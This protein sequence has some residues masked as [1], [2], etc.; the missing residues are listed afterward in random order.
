MMNVLEYG[1]IKSSDYHV[2]VL[3][4]TDETSTEREY[5]AVSVAGR[6]G[7]LHFD[8]GRY[9]NV[10]RRYQCYAREHAKDKVA[11][12]LAALLSLH[13]YQRIEDSMNPDYYKIGELAGSVEPRFSTFKSGA[14]FDLEFDCKP[15]KWLKSGEQ[16]H[17]ITTSGAIYN[18]TKFGSK[19]LI[20]I[21][22]YGNLG[23][24][25]DT[26][27]ISSGYSGNMVID[28]DT[29]DAYSK[30]GHANLNSYVTL[31]GGDFPEL[32]SGKN[33]ITCSSNL[34]VEIIPRWWTL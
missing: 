5:E 3:N 9:T 16:S 2:Y 26:I 25:G 7:D 14:R 23:I 34:S 33:N 32:K 17:V 28:F 31:T 29:G 20:Y 24:G 13:G 19:P 12:Y 11:D 22:G 21:T 18:P 27:T 30:V 8:N 4:N 15:Q 1:G 6:S 10:T